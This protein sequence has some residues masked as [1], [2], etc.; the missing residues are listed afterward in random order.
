MGNC[1]H[2]QAREEDNNEMKEGKIPKN[3]DILNI[4]IDD[5]KIDKENN[6]NEIKKSYNVSQNYYKNQD[7]MDSELLN[8]DQKKSED[9]FNF[10]N[11]LRNNPQN[12]ITE[13][14]KYN[15]QN[16]ISTAIN[17]SINE[18][19]K[20]LIKNPF[21]ELVLDKCVKKSPE[22]K[23]DIL[24]NLEKETQFKNYEKKLY[25]VLGDGEKPNDCIWGLLKNCEKEGENILEK[26]IDY[27]LITTMILEDKKNIFCYFLFLTQINK[28]IKQ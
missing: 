2:S 15:L 1:C 7:S 22:S 19:I 9:I 8:S 16:M 18:N 4:E 14:Q 5:N 17:K 11:D 13:A 20:N 3:E 26:D 12:Y 25:I 28:S 6:N 21:W 10:F 27:L 24:N 23:E